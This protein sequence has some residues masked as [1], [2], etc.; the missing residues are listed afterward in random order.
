[1]AEIISEENN[2][3]VKIKKFIV[4]E[5]TEYV[6]KSEEKES[7]INFGFILLFNHNKE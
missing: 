5:K 3:I 7:D 4:K 6:R 1:V 2:N